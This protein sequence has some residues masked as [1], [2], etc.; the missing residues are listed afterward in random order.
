MRAP[1][2]PLECPLR[3][4]SIG[5]SQWICGMTENIGR[6]GV[7][8]RTDRIV[9]VETNVEVEITLTWEAGGSQLSCSGRVVR[10]EPRFARPWGVAVTF[11]EAELR[12]LPGVTVE[13]YKARSG[14]L[15][16]G[17]VQRPRRV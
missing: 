10:A 16:G 13:S 7:L 14:E 12:P 6:S 9:D 8:F 3:Y 2:F 17:V 4:R 11:L 1:R 15:A 5:S